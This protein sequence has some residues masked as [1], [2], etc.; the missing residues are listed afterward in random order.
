MIYPINNHDDLLRFYLGP[1]IIKNA[2]MTLEVF[3][4]NKKI[5][6]FKCKCGE[7]FEGD[8][9]EL[10]KHIID[11]HAGLEHPSRLELD[12]FLQSII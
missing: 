9:K 10:R 8:E 1:L 7:L 11:K 2:P 3:G 12:A 6:S 4:S 5:Y